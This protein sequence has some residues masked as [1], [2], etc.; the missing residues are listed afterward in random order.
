MHV[1]IRKKITYTYFCFEVRLQ[2]DDINWTI[3][4][5]GGDRFQYD[6]KT[7]T[8]NDGKKQSRYTSTLQYQQRMQSMQ[9]PIYRTSTQTQNFNCPNTWKFT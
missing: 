1:P 4:T 7:S 6:G 9:Q 3:L 8:E 5:V 2:K